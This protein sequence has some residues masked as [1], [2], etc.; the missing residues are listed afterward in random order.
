MIATCVIPTDV[1]AE[2]P[3]EFATL[4]SFPRLTAQ[5]ERVSRD[6]AAE[7]SASRRG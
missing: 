1:R 7:R 5:L 6:A 3:D 2:N 4:K